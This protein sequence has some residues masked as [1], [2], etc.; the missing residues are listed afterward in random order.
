MLSSILS[1]EPIMT[2]MAP[3]HL[4]PQF[5]STGPSL[6][7][8]TAFSCHIS[9]A[10]FHLEH[11]QSFFVFYDRDTW[12]GYSCLSPCFF[13][14]A[15]SDVS[16]WSRLQFL[17][18]TL[19]RWCCVLRISHLEARGICLPLRGAV[20]FYPGQSTFQSPLCNYSF[21]L[22]TNK[23][24]VGE[25]V[26]QCEYPVPIH[27]LDLASTDESCLTQSLLRCRWRTDFSCPSMLSAFTSW[28]LAFVKQE[29]PLLP[30]TFHPSIHYQYWLNNSSSPVVYN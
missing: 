29:A 13:N 10:S 11:F 18:R 23:Q 22:T 2:L 21:S 8:L 12:E 24:S 9:L 27:F 6:G 4:D 30:T 7:S 20:H 17:A 28:H 15:L 16:S 1:V 26:T 25:S 3:L 14:R 19:Q 5:S